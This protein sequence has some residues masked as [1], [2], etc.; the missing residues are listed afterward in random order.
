MNSHRTAHRIKN[1]WW[2]V[3][4]LVA[5]LTL[6]QSGLFAAD[7]T[8]S[9]IRP[10]WSKE[11]GAYLVTADKSADLA[12]DLGD[13]DALLI[14]AVGEGSATQA[15]TLVRGDVMITRPETL[16]VGEL[17]TFSIDRLGTQYDVRVF[18]RE[19]EALKTMA[20]GA[21]GRA[22][23]TIVV[24][25]SGN[26]DCRT[27]TRALSIA[28]SGGTV[29]VSDGIYRELLYVPPNV[30]LKAREGHTP[31]LETALNVHGVSN[32]T[33]DGLILKSITNL[34][35]IHVVSAS[36][37]TLDN[38]E[39]EQVA[40]ADQADKSHNAIYAMDGKDIVVS[41]CRIDG[42]EKLFGINFNLT[43]AI[44]KEN[45]V[46]NCYLAMRFADSPTTRVTHNLLTGNLHGMYLKNSTATIS[47]NTITGTSKG[48]GAEAKDS[49]VTFQDN[50][51]RRNNRGV[52][53]TGGKCELSKNRFSQ[54]RWATSIKSGVT[55]IAGN[56][57]A[58]NYYGVSLF[59]SEDT[60]DQVRR[61]KIHR[62]SFSHNEQTA[63]G[64]GAGA[65]VEIAFNLIEDS[66]WGV[67]AKDAKCQIRNNTIVTQSAA[68]VDIVGKSQLQ[69]QDNI[70]AFNLR[71][72][73]ISSEA[74]LTSAANNV[75]GNLARKTLP[76]ADGNYIRVDWI[77][78]TTGDHYLAD[79]F[80]AYDLASSSDEHVDPKFVKLGSDY[81][82][83][84]NSPL[85]EM[86]GSNGD[87]IGALGVATDITVDDALTLETSITGK[88]E[89]AVA[90]PQ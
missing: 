5:A 34:V 45:V 70:I 65:D 28:G 26:G 35:P 32:V 59:A 23:S 73:R 56:T 52:A 54:N 50:T 31:M 16:E 83:A 86:T 27:I 37:V 77:P 36:N 43:E 29:L 49:Q 8:D 42:R 62:N 51:L 60:K 14:V 53:I 87:G 3:G 22:G 80:P 20:R 41:N 84:S 79:I 85:A 21:A 30:T 55:E 57:Y 66:R 71:G 17:A 9:I 6:L 88:Q 10:F 25:L 68:G 78:M 44:V 4:M 40:S 74:S 7:D 67:Y 76:L 58:D 12:K 13:D 38:L 2:F 81:R 75:F 61:A 33:I 18:A 72:I 24:D 63:I 39:V 69:L 46:S 11:L 15:A 82:V 1:H 48:D 90:K 89:D 19:H 64:M 47:E